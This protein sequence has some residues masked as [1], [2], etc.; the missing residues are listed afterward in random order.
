MITHSNR[1]HGAAL[2]R[3]ANMRL[4]V[5]GLSM[6]FGAILAMPAAAQSPAVSESAQEGTPITQVIES[7]ARRTGKKLVVDPRVHG[8]V[9]LFGQDPSRVDYDELLL[10]LNEDGFAAVEEEGYVRVMPDAQIRQTA[11]PIVTGNENLPGAQ[12]VTTIIR[13]KSVQAAYLVPILRPLLPLVGHLAALPCRNTLI[14]VDTLAN[15]RRIKALIESL[16]T[17]EPLSPQRCDMPPPARD[18]AV[19]RDAP[20]QAR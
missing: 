15:V 9:M 6:L 16:D 18:G 5:P 2:E 10:I 3:F 8:T 13:V 17:G 14:M 19:S 1:R 12:Y 7:V 4:S 11:L 20:A